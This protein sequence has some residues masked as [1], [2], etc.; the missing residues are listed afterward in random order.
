MPATLLFICSKKP[1]NKEEK[2][3]MGDFEECET[4]IN[5]EFDPFQCDSCED[6]SNYESEDNSEELTYTE[7]IDL[8]KDAA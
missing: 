4:C 1:K 8:F 3:E 7:F 6:A 5:R 2:L